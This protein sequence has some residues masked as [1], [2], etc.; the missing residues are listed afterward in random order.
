MFFLHVLHAGA[1]ELPDTATDDQTQ[2]HTCEVLTDSNFQLL[3]DYDATIYPVDRS[4]MLQVFLNHP[5]VRE[6]LIA[7]ATDGKCVGYICIRK[8][9][10]EFAMICPLVADNDAI[11]DLLLRQAV[12]RKRLAGKTAEVYIPDVNSAAARQ[13]F[14]TYGITKQSTVETVMCTKP[15]EA[16]RITVPWR[17]TY[18]VFFNNWTFY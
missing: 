18:G 1:L 16:R 14:A 8:T 13:L 3:A 9:G 10:D 5:S 2:H 7:V 6:T 17:K 15:D 4:K 11:A 12:E